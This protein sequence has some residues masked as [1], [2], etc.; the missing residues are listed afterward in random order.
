[1][2]K[3]PHSSCNLSSVRSINVKA[4]FKVEMLRVLFYPEPPMIASRYI[5]DLILVRKFAFYFMGEI[6]VQ[7]GVYIHKESVGSRK[8]GIF[9]RLNNF[10]S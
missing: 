3:M 9:A 8:S 7:V 5:L 10:G 2:P 4:S 1:M 6:E